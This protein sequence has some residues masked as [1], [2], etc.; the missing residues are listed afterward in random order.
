MKYNK[1][2]MNNLAYILSR[3]PLKKVTVVGGTIQLEPFTD[4]LLGDEYKEDEEF[5]GVYKNMKERLV[6]SNEGNE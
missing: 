1:G 2:F 4:T 6:G 3:L 5:I